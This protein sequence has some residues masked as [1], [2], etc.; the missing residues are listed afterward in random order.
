MLK[1][2]ARRGKIIRFLAATA[3]LLLPTWLYAAEPSY[4]TSLG[5][6]F[7]S[8]QYGTGIRTD[9]VFVPFT[10][11]LNPTRRLDFSLEL[12]YVYQSTS[13]V[14]AG[15]FMAMQS[16]GTSSTSV[17]A[18]MGG[19]GTGMSGPLTT[20]SATTV[21]KAQNGVGDLTL[22]AG[23]IVV[24]EGDYLPAVRPN[25]SLKIPTADK[26]KFLG[27]GAFDEALGVEFSK[28]YGDWLADAETGYTFQGKS[29]VLS[30]K[31]YFYYAIGGGYQ[32]T[33]WLRPMLLFKGSTPRVEG[34]AAQ[35]EARLRVKYQMSEHTGL[36]GYLAKGLTTASPDYGTGLAVY[37]EF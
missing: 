32:L 22:K 16:M 7:T 24:P 17:G 35:L 19:P 10:V 12:P 28:W 5:F 31:D 29:T 18:V 15:Q 1:R 6:E 37:V 27:T 14:V 21:N 3:A 36:D 30:V 13:S 11:S 2:H 26:N 23:Y 9:A 33:D 4:S 8:G 34:A 20:A 25:F